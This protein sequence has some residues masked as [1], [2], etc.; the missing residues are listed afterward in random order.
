MPE[1]YGTHADYMAQV[2]TSANERAAKVAEALRIAFRS[3]IRQ[4]MAEVVVF[5]ALS[6]ID[7]SRAIVAQPIIL[8]GLL[9][10]ANVAARAIERDL[11]IKNLDTYNPRITQEEALAISGYIKPYLPPT[12]P[13]TALSQLDRVQF[14][15]KEVRKYKG[16]WEKKVLRALNTFGP[17][18]KKRSFVSQDEEYELDA[19]SPISGAIEYGID[20]K[21]IEARR[22]I[23][24]RCDEIVNKGRHLKG[25]YPGAKF[26]AVIYYPFIE[27]HANIQ[28]RLRSEFVDSV[29][30]A[31]EA[32]DSIENAVRLVLS[33]L[34]ST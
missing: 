3:V 23:H 15:D 7:L 20:I 18:F 32:E 14:I 22:D 29:I 28:D 6:A 16:Q 33:K 34:R 17:P 12:L 8:K 5:S 24:K 2:E 31:S 21:R 26:G 30:F 9:A 25:A 11:Q 4:E 1:G 19:A 13:L 10:A 27:E